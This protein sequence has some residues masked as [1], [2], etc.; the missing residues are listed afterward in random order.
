MKNL[1]NKRQWLVLTFYSDAALSHCHW[2]G[3]TISFY[4]SLFSI[5]IHFWQLT[6]VPHSESK[7]K[8]P[9]KLKTN[10]APLASKTFTTSI[11]VIADHKY[12]SLP[13]ISQNTVA[14]NSQSCSN[15]K[16]N[17]TSQ[18]KQCSAKLQA[19]PK[20]Y[21]H[22]EHSCVWKRGKYITA[23]INLKYSHRLI[24]HLSRRTLLW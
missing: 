4:T 5:S 24:S 7:E 13:V 22:R 15:D 6:F 1:I 16:N 21:M 12:L 23:S 11:Y 2:T 19:V 3:V 20:H 8:A 14:E 17:D 9:S 18:W 10:P